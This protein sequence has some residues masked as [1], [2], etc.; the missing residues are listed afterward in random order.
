MTDTLKRLAE[1]LESRKGAAPDS[2]PLR[3][4]LPRERDQ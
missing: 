4:S 2:S 1:V 3:H